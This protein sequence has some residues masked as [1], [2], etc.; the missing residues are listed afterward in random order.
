MVEKKTL[1]VHCSI[2]S[3]QVEVV[4]PI[5]L[6]ENRDYYPFEYLNIHGNPEHGLMLY[7]DENLTVR[8]TMVYEEINVAEEQIPDQ[9]EKLCQ[10][11]MMEIIEGI[12]T[13]NYCPNNHAVHCDCLKEWMKHSKKCPK[14]N[15]SYSKDILMILP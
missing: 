6:A 10:I 13:V 15:A 9:D 14:C 8:E 4:V 5:N 12:D 2:C 1:K 3:K 7:I 11:C